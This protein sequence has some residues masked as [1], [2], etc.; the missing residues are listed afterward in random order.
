[1]RASRLSSRATDAECWVE[2]VVDLFSCG[3]VLG[4]EDVALLMESGSGMGK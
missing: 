2:A 3:E 1:M 4:D